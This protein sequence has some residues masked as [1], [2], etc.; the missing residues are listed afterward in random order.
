MSDRD[1]RLRVPMSVVT[2]PEA[3]PHHDWPRFWCRY[4]GSIRLDQLGYLEDPARNGG[5]KNPDVV[6]F[7][8][9]A[10]APFL[11]LLGEAGIGKTTTVG[12]IVRGLERAGEAV[13][14]VDL[15]TV[16]TARDL[17]DQVSGDTRVQA[18]SSSSG[19]LHLFFDG[20]DEAP[21]SHVDVHVENLLT[22]L[23]RSRLRVRLV[24][25]TGDWTLDMDRRFRRMWG[26]L[27][28]AYELVYLRRADVLLAAHDRIGDPENF[29]ARAEAMNI[30]PLLT[31][32]VT[33]KLILNLHQKGELP[34]TRRV[35]YRRACRRLC[36]TFPVDVLVCSFS[37]GVAR[38]LA[39][40]VVG[41]EASPNVVVVAH[42]LALL[43][44]KF[45]TGARRSSARA[46]RPATPCS[47]A[48]IYFRSAQVVV[49]NSLPPVSVA[50]RPT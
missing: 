12:E 15:R 29:M 4:D 21:L 47:S 44:A 38:S 33:L 39:A 36:E 41:G 2:A 46:F 48:A 34:P 26:D 32:P 7:A 19:I 28:A 17:A 9:I 31:R 14:L 50:P 22:E 35:L 30:V 23:D 13:R 18:W 6:P 40:P 20:L 8:A 11:A 10:H 42:R 43:A 37:R 49:P 27:F 5:R 24:C 3:D 45:H 16:A 1:G 25:R